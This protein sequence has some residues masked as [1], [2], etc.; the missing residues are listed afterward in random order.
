VS[1]LPEQL[2]QLLEAGDRDQLLEALTHDTLAQKRNRALILLLSTGA[3][4]SE[5]LRFDRSEWKLERLWVLGEGDRE[6]GYTEITA[7][8][9]ARCM[10]RCSASDCERT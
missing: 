3:R 6:S 4:S 5:V 10:R 1:S 2:P 9:R 8:R 7:Q